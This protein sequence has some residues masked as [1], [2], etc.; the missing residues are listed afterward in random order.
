MLQALDSI[1]L[2]LD[3][4]AI[5]SLV[6]LP[7]RRLARLAQLCCLEFHQTVDLVFLLAY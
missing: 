2:A 5:H 3:M 7:I 6:V 1:D 4:V